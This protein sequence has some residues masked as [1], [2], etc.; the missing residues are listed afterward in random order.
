MAS[1]RSP[2]PLGIGGNCTQIL[3][4]FDRPNPSKRNVIPG[5]LGVREAPPDVAEICRRAAS[6][7]HWFETNKHVVTVLGN[8]SFG[9]GVVYG[10]GESVVKS[11]FEMFE[12]GRTF[13]LA[14]LYDALNSHD[15][16]WRQVARNGA[17][18]PAKHMV[19]LVAQH[20]W[21]EQLRKAHEERDDLIAAVTE[22]IK[23]P[24]SVLPAMKD[25]YARKWSDYEPLSKEPLLSSRFKAGEIFGELLL[26][27]ITLLTTIVGLAVTLMR[28]L[29]KLATLIKK[30]H[31]VG[32]GM[33]RDRVLKAP[34][35]VALEIDT[36][37]S[38][39]GARIAKAKGVKGH[40]SATPKTEP[41]E[42]VPPRFEYGKTLASVWVP[43]RGEPKPRTGGTRN[44]SQPTEVVNN[45]QRVLAEADRGLSSHGGTFSLT[46]NSAGGEV[47]TSTG[48][49]SQNDFAT[50][51]NSGIYKGDV[52][53]I[54]GVHGS[55]SGLTEVAN[56]LFK[57]DVMRFGNIPGVKVYNFAE[58][59]P[60]EI[61]T[62]LRGPGTTI[63]GFCDSGACLAPLF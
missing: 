62:L 21:S 54:S 59:S 12:L 31:R 63:G 34:K 17:L 40:N 3:G 55:P 53:I 32:A 56:D 47:W 29:P 14:D 33:I 15:P 41:D 57:A 42:H 7:M 52:N 23:H 30:L 19:A 18:W 39:D 9:L 58:M 45:T 26:D 13:A 44:T 25:E 1:G 37:A 48:K 20:Y 24:S 38:A 10:M 35:A 22:I 60:Q 61:T 50:Y 46:K 27:I 5:P 8:H 51:V 6:A 4:E 11:V 43:K 49:I 16:I 2:W 28:V 36:L